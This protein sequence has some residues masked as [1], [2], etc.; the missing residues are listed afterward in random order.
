MQVT[1]FDMTIEEGVQ[2]EKLV[3]A[4]V[5]Q[6]NSRNRPPSGVTCLD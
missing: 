3:V 4:H 6:E 2:A 1:P 5:A